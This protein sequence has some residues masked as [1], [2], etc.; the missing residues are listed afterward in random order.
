MPSGPSLL[1]RR[2]EAGK[3]TW[4][5]WQ[6][7][8]FEARS[9]WDRS[10]ERREQ[11]RRVVS[12]LQFPVMM[13]RDRDDYIDD[14]TAASQQ[15]HVD[16][17][18]L[19]LAIRYL[20]KLVS[21]VGDEVPKITWER[22]W[23]SPWERH[24]AKFDTLQERQASRA[25][26]PENNAEGAK[27]VCVDGVTSY[28]INFV[29]PLTASDLYRAT[30]SVDQVI[31]RVLAD[32]EGYQPAPGAEHAMMAEVFESRADD[33]QT[34]ERDPSGLVANAL[35]LAAQKHYEAA[36]KDAKHP[37]L[38]RRDRLELQHE[39]LPYGSHALMDPS[40]TSFRNCRWV[41][42]L[43]RMPVADARAHP[44]FH[45]RIRKDLVQDSAEATT[46]P[47]KNEM[48][49]WS[50]AVDQTEKGEWL[51]MCSIWEI[52]DRKHKEIIY[53][54]QNVNR[55]LN[56]GKVNGTSRMRHPFLDQKGMALIPPIGPYPGFFPCF[57]FAPSE[58]QREDYDRKTG[59]PLLEPGMNILFA[60]TKLLSH[61]VGTVKRASSA[62][63]EA[64]PKLGDAARR[65][66][67][68]GKDG[69]IFTRPADVPP[70][71]SIVAVQW[72]PPSEQLFRQI[73]EF[74][75]NWCMVQ[76]FP[77]G[78]L[79]TK[80]VAETATQEK[81]GQAAGDAWQQEII[82][83]FEISYAVQCHILAHLGMYFTDRTD[84]AE[85]V[86]MQEATLLHKLVSEI[87]FPPELPGVRLA[88][89]RRGGDVVRIEQLM[90]LDERV[91]SYV[92]PLSGLPVNDRGPILDELARVLEV[93][94][95]QRYVPDEKMMQMIAEAKVRMAQEQNLAQPAESGGPAARQTSSGNGQGQTPPGA[96]P[97]E[98]RPAQGGSPGGS[99]S[100]GRTSDS[101]KKSR[102]GGRRGRAGGAP[103]A[104]ALDSKAQDVRKN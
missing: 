82:R 96:N 92:D 32:P 73:Y 18:D 104:D 43:I 1:G 4:E 95:L 3:E 66:I 51:G 36:A 58:P 6:T 89:K 56:A 72:K 8:L 85:L 76:S 63:Y 90:T 65:S 49:R 2:T 35:Y 50:D 34:D 101:A 62:I 99:A 75:Q 86:G 13:W 15:P 78:E 55:F 45:P 20:Q 5:F 28:W 61:Y 54:N 14:K 98:M 100:N 84:W 47:V 60:I 87:R 31:D 25:G 21:N 44:A 7:Q 88:S 64:H 77:L 46:D 70:G 22:E 30:E 68:S 83:K 40:A 41:A 74:I 97:V 42:R 12:E 37:W 11:I 91:A 24:A 80:P 102:R 38:W 10:S 19:N 52:H 57:F 48:R 23:T 53:F 17:I 16:Q 93:G 39:R 71:E 67:K 103:T 33:F 9:Q 69:T 59:Q 29:E 26:M 81:M 94:K 27:D 79:T